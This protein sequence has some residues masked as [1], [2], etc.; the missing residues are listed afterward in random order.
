[1]FEK[2]NYFLTTSLLQVSAAVALFV[3]GHIES[4]NLLTLV[5]VI[6]GIY[7]GM[8]KGI[9]QA[10]M[11]KLWGLDSMPFLQM[12]CF[13]QNFGG[14]IAP[15]I[16][17]PYLIRDQDSHD[18]IISKKTLL[19]FPYAMVSSIY[20]FSGAASFLVWILN[21]ETAQHHSRLQA[22]TPAT[23]EKEHD[24]RPIESSQNKHFRFWKIV[25]IVCMAIFS[26]LFMGV[27]LMLGSFLVAFVTKSDLHLSKGIGVQMITLYW[28]L[29]TIMSFVCTFYIPYIGNRYSV[30]MNCIIT[31][32]GGAI[33][34]MFGD[35]SETALWIAVVILVIGNVGCYGCSIRY[36]EGF[37]MVTGTINSVIAFGIVVGEVVNPSIFSLFIDDHPMILPWFILI[38]SVVMLVLFSAIML[39]CNKFLRTQGSKVDK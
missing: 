28:T 37:F 25:V 38:A 15:V 1:M 4:Y 35:S 13:F 23:H 21:P 12:M 34:V 27:E 20:I 11:L 8:S 39:I 22:V 31:L 3:Y 9:E 26:G 29:E 19:A 33:M 36:M 24:D 2:Y 6:T 16:L 14:I 7:M 5:T 32:I 17:K 30:I 10:F 18:D